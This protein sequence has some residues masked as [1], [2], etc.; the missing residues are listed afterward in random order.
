MKKIIF[1][2]MIASLLAF[3]GCQNEELV[4][5]NTNNGNGKKRK[6]YTKRAA[7]LCRNT[8]LLFWEK[9]LFVANHKDIDEKRYKRAQHQRLSRNKQTLQ[10]RHERSPIRYTQK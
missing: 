5:E 10:K 2:T 9:P 1:S 4:N 6:H 7:K 3:V 8:A